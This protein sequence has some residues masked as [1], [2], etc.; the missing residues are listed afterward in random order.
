MV[1]FIAPKKI[2]RGKSTIALT[3][4]SVN[5][6]LIHGAHFAAPR[7]EAPRKEKSV[8]ADNH[9]FSL[10]FLPFP[11]WNTTFIIFCAPFLSELDGN[12]FLLYDP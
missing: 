11:E 6:V 7:E 1:S 10:F 3:A 5:G 12:F 2:S 9:D 8:L 4:N